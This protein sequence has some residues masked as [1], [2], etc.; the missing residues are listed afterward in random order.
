M[1]Q[2]VWVKVFPPPPVVK[3]ELPGL[4]GWA[5][6]T[7]VTGSPQ[8]TTYTDASGTNWKVWTFTADGSITCTAGLLDCLV[9]GGGGNGPIPSL[10][11]VPG[12]VSEG[13]HQFTAGVQAVVVGPEGPLNGNTTVSSIGSLAVRVSGDGFSRAGSGTAYTS[14]ITGTAVAY[15]QPWDISPKSYG[16]AGFG[17]GG[18]VYAHPGVVI[19]RVPAANAKA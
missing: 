18:D 2:G 17:T 19:V 12:V 8:I 13:L 5:D 15:C 6:I 14:S 11:G 3:P 16:G 10:A 1:A 4:G 9:I 7:A